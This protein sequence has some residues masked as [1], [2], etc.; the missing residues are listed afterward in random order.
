MVYCHWLLGPCGRWAVKKTGGRAAK[1]PRFETPWVERINKR[2]IHMFS[3]RSPQ[4]CPA[5]SAP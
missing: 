2:R 4:P 1:I 5:L 3:K